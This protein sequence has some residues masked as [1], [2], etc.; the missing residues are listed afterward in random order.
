MQVRADRSLRSSTSSTGSGA[1][2][3][4]AK[5]AAPARVS[6]AD[7]RERVEQLNFALQGALQGSYD[8]FI[9]GT[10]SRLSAQGGPMVLPTRT[11]I[12]AA[13]G[14]KASLRERMTASGTAMQQSAAAAPEKSCAMQATSSEFF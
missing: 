12:T 2:A 5:S 6:L 13:S 8:E 3:A 7:V 9:Q 14:R 10:A 4:V 1:P 11:A